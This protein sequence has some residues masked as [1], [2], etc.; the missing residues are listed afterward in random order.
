[1]L[2]MT[3]SL[4][5]AMVKPGIKRVQALADISRSA[6]CCHSNET[7]H[8][9]QIRPIVHD[10]SRCI[11]YHPHNWHPGTCSSVG[12]R[13]RTDTQT[14]VTNIHFA[15]ATPH[16]KC[17]RGPK[18]VYT[19]AFDATLGVYPIA[20]CRKSSSALLLCTADWNH[21]DSAFTCR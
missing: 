5:A 15:S 1:M 9:L 21:H 13:R 11:P 17:N 19:S 12:M 6:L 16:A 10:Y 20:S 18:L 2:I 3:L 8:R 4:C 7:V 14:A